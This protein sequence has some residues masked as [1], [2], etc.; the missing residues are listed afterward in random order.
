MAAPAALRK[1]MLEL[2]LLSTMEAP[3]EAVS[4]TEEAVITPQRMWLSAPKPVV[5]PCEV[6]GN[7]LL[8]NR[9]TENDEKPWTPPKHSATTT[10]AKTAG[11]R[12]A[13]MAE[14]RSRCSCAGAPCRTTASRGGRAAA[15]RRLAA[16]G[17]CVLH[18]AACGTRS[19]MRGGS[20]WP[21]RRSSWR[22]EHATAAA[23]EV[24]RAAG[25]AVVVVVPAALACPHARR[26]LAAGARD[27]VTRLRNAVSL[28]EE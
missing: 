1:V 15:S 2:V 24:Q 25:A 4:V 18:R 16:A 7:A 26:P 19:S 8:G 28:L 12:A 23:R 5:P 3:L 20:A 9:S 11:P 22:D 13:R 27:N 17:R 10:Q 6:Q 21:W 14:A